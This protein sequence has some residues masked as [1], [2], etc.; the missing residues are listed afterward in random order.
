MLGSKIG[1]QKTAI[2]SGKE[3]QNIATYSTKENKFYKR[4]EYCPGSRTEAESMRTERGRTASAEMNKRGKQDLQ[5]GS[6]VLIRARGKQ[7]S[8]QKIK[9]VEL[10]A[11]Q[12][13]SEGIAEQDAKERWNGGSIR[14]K[15]KQK[16]IGKGV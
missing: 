9:N 4:E 3:W 11:L 14:E 10:F 12:R 1:Q 7:T 8:C 5:R 2:I 15:E 6:Q 16:S 13:V